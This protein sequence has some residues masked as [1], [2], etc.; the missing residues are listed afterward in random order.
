MPIFTNIAGAFRLLTDITVNA[1]GVLH[2]L[3]TVNANENGL[4]HEIHSAWKAP[5][6]LKWSNGATGLSITTNMG[7]SVP[8]YTECDIC[9]GTKVTVTF[10]INSTGSNGTVG[11]LDS[12][13]KVITSESWSTNN[14]S[15][16]VSAELSAGTYKIQAN[17]GGASGQYPNLSFFGYDITL[18]VTFSR[19]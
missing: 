2:E 14:R 6:T 13:N 3:D 8:V 10:N 17:G 11:I 19:A 1:G 18:N 16:I 9:Q 4:L 5:S 7:Y 12:S 15:G